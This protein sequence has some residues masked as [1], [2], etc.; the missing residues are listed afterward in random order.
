MPKAK[1]QKSVSRRMKITKTGKVKRFQ[2]LTSHLMVRRSRKRK[3]NLRK[4]SLVVGLQA[5]HMRRLMGG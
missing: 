3:R 5:R 1:T 4:S 2:A